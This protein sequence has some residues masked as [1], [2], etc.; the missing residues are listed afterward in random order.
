[1]EETIA[2]IQTQLNGLTNNVI[3][4]SGTQIFS[5]YNC[6]VIQIYDDKADNNRIK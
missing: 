4:D 1:L 5:T 6:G 3:K 2:D